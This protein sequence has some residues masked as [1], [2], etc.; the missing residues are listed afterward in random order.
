MTIKYREGLYGSLA[1]NSDL[2]RERALDRLELHL[3]RVG[4]SDYRLRH[5]GEKAGPQR[6]LPEIMRRVRKLT[7][8]HQDPG[9]K[10][11]VKSDS[12]GAVA[13]GLLLVEPK[14]P[15]TDTPGNDYVDR[16]YTAVFAKFKTAS[17][18][19]NCYCR[20]IEGSSSWSQHAFCN[21]QDFGAP[22]GT[23]FWPTLN[24]IANY[25]VANA[26]QFGTETVIVQDRIWLRGEGW[27]HYSGQYHYH[28]HTDGYP[29]G[30]GTPDCAK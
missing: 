8:D 22:S 12:P 6:S 11:E 7:K 13:Y 19:G 24:A 10:L 1:D 26:A 30:V 16:V 9:Y 18:L 14:P 17:N 4:D 21:A 25:I 20:R 29:N 3:S 28:V 27:R 2:G 23:Q 15:I 5:P